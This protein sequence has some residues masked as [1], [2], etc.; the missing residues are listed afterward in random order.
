MAIAVT[1]VTLIFALVGTL[2]VG[3]HELYVFGRSLT[4]DFPLEH[5]SISRRHAAIVREAPSARLLL[6]DLA[7]KAGVTLNG[8]CIATSPGPHP[9]MGPHRRML[10]WRATGSA[11]A[12][13]AGH[14]PA[15]DRQP[16]RLC[17]GRPRLV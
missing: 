9:A 13:R 7:S 2:G 6:V 10:T 12:G 3:E 1:I 5:P 15:D 8:R 11:S 17:G 14:A 4:C 16:A